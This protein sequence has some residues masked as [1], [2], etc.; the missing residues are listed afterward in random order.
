M[1][2]TDPPEGHTHTWYS[3]FKACYRY[4][5]PCV[6]TGGGPDE[7]NIIHQAAMKENI[8]QELKSATFTVDLTA[9]NAPLQAIRTDVQRVL[10]CLRDREVTWETLLSVGD[11]TKDAPRIPLKGFMMETKSYEP[12]THL[13]NV[14]ILA[15]NA[16]LTGPRLLEMLCF[17]AHDAEMKEKLDSAKPLKP[18]ILGLLDPP[19]LKKQKVSWNEVAVIVEV[20]ANLR[21]KTIILRHLGI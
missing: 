15:A 12:F 8:F 20:K 10:E 19:P 17:H 7:H 9:H 6:P 13:L 4:A 18:D 16:C 11:S 14:I 2:T 1:T 5:S 3:E 21:L